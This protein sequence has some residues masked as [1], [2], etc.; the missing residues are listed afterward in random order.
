MLG[1]QEIAVSDNLCDECNKLID[2]SRHT[3]PHEHLVQTEFV[4]VSSA[5]GPA[6]EWRYECSKC[7]HKWLREIG[8]QGYGWI[9]LK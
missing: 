2:A 7:G 6:D 5:I 3:P 4:K 1:M 8:S 9:K